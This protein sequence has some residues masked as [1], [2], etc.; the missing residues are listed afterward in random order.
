M[1]SVEQSKN[2]VKKRYHKKSYQLSK[3][4]LHSFILEVSLSISIS[5]ALL[6]WK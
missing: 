3:I 4:K 2:S 5:T 6:L 1:K